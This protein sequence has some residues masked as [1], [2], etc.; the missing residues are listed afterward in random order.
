MSG[1]MHTQQSKLD[2]ARK[3]CDMPPNEV[4]SEWRRVYSAVLSTKTSQNNSASNRKKL[5]QILEATQ[6]CEVGG[7][8]WQSG[9]LFANDT[10]Q[11]GLAVPQEQRGHGGVEEEDA[12]EGVSLE[13]GNPR[14][15]T[16]IRFKIRFGFPCSR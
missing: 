3:R 2:R 14:Q 11:S 8:R 4:S 12:Q 1:D 7:M 16:T 15:R 10:Y 6:Y 13:Q 5:S 9:R